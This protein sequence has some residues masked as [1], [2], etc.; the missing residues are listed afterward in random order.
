MA[1]NGEWT[2]GHPQSPFSIWDTNRASMEDCFPC[3]SGR[4]LED[5]R[6]SHST[7]A[8][9]WAPETETIQADRNQ[10]SWLKFVDLMQAPGWSAVPPL[11]CKPEAVSR[12]MLQSGQGSNRNSQPFRRLAGWCT[13]GKQEKLQPNVV[14]KYDPLMSFLIF[15]DFFAVWLVLCTCIINYCR[16][17]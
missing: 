9:G 10:H 8:S 17:A 12:G 11:E 15:H 7:V 4:R 13:A 14:S 2:P 16:P 6:L 5:P 1:G 3:K